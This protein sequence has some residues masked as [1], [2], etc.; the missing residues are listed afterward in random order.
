[1]D[2]FNIA[3]GLASIGG[4]L[5]SFLAWRRA[6]QAAGAAEEAR[7]AVTIRTL[8]DE[9]QLACERV[10][11]LLDFIAHE[12]FSEASLRASELVSALSEIPFRRS[13]LGWT[14]GLRQPVK[15]RIAVR[16]KVLDRQYNCTSE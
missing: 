6:K 12:R 10:D 4:V 3:A 2:W 7:K 9:F 13:P 16:W 8:A 5:F 14:P 15:L 1:M 11:Q